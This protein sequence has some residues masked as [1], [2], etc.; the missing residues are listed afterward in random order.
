MSGKIHALEPQTGAPSDFEVD[1]RQADRNAGAPI[2]D[3]VQEA[4]ARV[5]VVL[6]ITGEAELFEEVGVQRRDLASTRSSPRACSRAAA[7]SPMRSRRCRYGSI[8][9]PGYS[10]RA[11]ASAAGAIACLD[12]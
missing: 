8:S 4:V 2:E 11:I 6:A 10:T 5:V 9:S 7:A 12:R 3:L 1:D